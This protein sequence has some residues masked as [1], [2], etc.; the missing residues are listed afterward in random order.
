MYQHVDALPKFRFVV[1]FND[2]HSS[3]YIGDY[4]SIINTNLIIIQHNLHDA[5]KNIGIR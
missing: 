3:A 5:L 4:L 1:L 2:D